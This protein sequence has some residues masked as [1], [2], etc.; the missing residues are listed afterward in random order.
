MK[1]RII[2][3]A[4]LLASAGVQAQEIEG[5]I[6]YLVTHN[7]SKKMAAVDYISKQ[8]RERIAYMWGNRSEWKMFANMY[9]T[10]TV[11]KYEDS[12]EKAEPDDEGYSWRKEVF[13][14]K[15]DYAANTMQDVVQI[16]GK[17][18]IVEDSLRAPEWKILNDL[19][20]VA[21]HICMKA[22]WTDTL[23][24][25]KV[26]AWFA[27]DI[28]IS[29]GP[30]RFYGLPGLILEVDVNDGGMLVSADKIDL[31]KITTELDLP[32]KLKAKKISE[33]EYLALLKKH[34]DQKKEEE[35]PPFWGIRY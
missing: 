17:T 25:Q 5:T 33:A 12:E 21:G 23:K 8:Q 14:V 9:I 24:Q 22:S 2:V 4:L 27:M 3:I 20:E 19:K 1:Q 13:M 10:P 32:K 15:H 28:P 7:W 6:R 34:M 18:Y 30:E 29:A 11:T 16:F 26:I 35:E 31:K